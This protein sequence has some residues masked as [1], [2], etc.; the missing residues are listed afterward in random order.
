[1]DNLASQLSKWWY[2]ESYASKCDV[3]GQ[4]KD[5][6]RAF[7]TLEQT[8]RFTG[9]RYEVGLLWREDEENLPNNFYSAMGQ[10]KSLER[11]LQKDDML[12]KRYQETNDTDVNAGYVW[13]VDQTEL[14][15][16]RDKLQWYLPRHPVINPHKPEKVRRVCHAAAKY[17]GVALNDK[18]LSGPDLLQ[19]LIGIIFRFREHQIALSADI[20]AMF[21]QFAVPSDEN[22]CLQF[23]WREDPVGRIEVY[24]Y[25][26]HV[27][28]AKIKWQKI[29]RKMRKILSKLSSETSTWTT[30]SSQSE[31][32]KKLLKSTRKSQRSLAKVDS[33]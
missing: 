10:C 23:L 21:L 7:K 31:Q 5:E 26:R 3:S 15:E 13:K 9:E 16:T 22:R 24:E 11:R 29:T 8:T 2:I 1:M 4:S 33:I 30:S 25:T 20:E 27:F 28:A 12:R 18:L 14:N 17:Q 6:Q 32:P 19:S